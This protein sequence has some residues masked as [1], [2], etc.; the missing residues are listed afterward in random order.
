MFLA[1][2]LMV[3]IAEE[4]LFRGVLFRAVYDRSG[5]GAWICSV[6][7]FA[8]VHVIGYIGQYDWILFSLAFAQYIPA[9]IALCFAYRRSGTIVAPMIMHMFINLLAFLAI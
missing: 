8:A 4:L 2:V 7:S 5:L 3:P 1:I 6:F 9:G